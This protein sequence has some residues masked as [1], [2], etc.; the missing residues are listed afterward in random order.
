[1]NA[2]DMLVLLKSTT[3]LKLAIG[4]MLSDSKTSSVL[5][6][7][8]TRHRGWQRGATSETTGE[9]H[10]KTLYK[11]REAFRLGSTTAPDKSTGTTSTEMIKRGKMKQKQTVLQ[12]HG[13]DGGIYD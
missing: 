10:A 12:H 3:T 13:Q 8:R 5:L 2:K 6:L 4:R 11:A 7:M 9:E 1:L